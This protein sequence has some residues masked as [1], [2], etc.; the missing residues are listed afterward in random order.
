MIARRCTPIALALA[1]VLGGCD[2]APPPTPTRKAAAT[3]EPKVATPDPKTGACP[4]DEAVAAIHASV[5]YFELG[6]PKRGREELA[7]A[8]AALPPV[9]ERD[10]AVIF[11]ML[12]EVAEFSDAQLETQKVAAEPIRAKLHEWACL[13]EA[14]HTTLHEALDKDAAATPDQP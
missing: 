11:S 7:R 10:T 9:A 1:L 4:P 14:L 13:P 2:G 8:R 3:Q 6:K 5:R 12:V